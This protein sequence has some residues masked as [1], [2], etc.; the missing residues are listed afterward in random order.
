MDGRRQTVEKEKHPRTC[1]GCGEK[2]SKRGMMRVVRTPEGE[3][4]FDPTGKAN[5]R[6]AYLC[7][8]IDCVRMAR[9]KKSL[10]KVLKTQVDECVYNM[11]ESLCSEEKAG[12]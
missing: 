4:K 9:K 2:S 12:V 1:A 11:L 5:G 3:V 6:G 8:S 10:A 7:R